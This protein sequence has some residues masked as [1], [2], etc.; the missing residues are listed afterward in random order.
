MI[1]GKLEAA[2]DRALAGDYSGAA[3]TFDN[4]WSLK[5]TQTFHPGY[6]LRLSTPGMTVVND[7]ARITDFRTGEVTHTWT[8]QYGTWQRRVFVSRADQVIVHELLPATGRT[9]DTT[10]SV[11]TALDGVPANVSYATTATVTGGDGYLNLR[12]TYPAGGAHGYEGVTRVV[13]SGTN[14]S[15]TAAGET[16]V[17]ARATRVLLLT[18]LGRY[19]TATGWDAKPLQTALAALTAAYATLLGRHAVPHQAMYD[20]STLDLNVPTADRQLPTSELVARQKSNASAVDIALLE[21]MYDSGRYL[22]VSSS[23]V[24]PPRLTG[25]WTGTWNGFWPTTSPPTPTSTSRSPA[26]TSSTSATPCRATS[27]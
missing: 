18:K 16:L 7:F 8:D 2:R 23:G 10:L 12:G 17:V 6:E 19:E 15:V 22:F 1:S 13:V 26:A 5:W 9:V 25:I 4:G 27:T 11:N 21:R 24:L 14:A 20:R 3:S